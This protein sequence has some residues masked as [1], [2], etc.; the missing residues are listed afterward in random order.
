MVTLPLDAPVT[1]GLKTTLKVRL[2]EG[3]KV[4]GTPAPL[5]V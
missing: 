5:K 4:T 2:C 1:A 3:V